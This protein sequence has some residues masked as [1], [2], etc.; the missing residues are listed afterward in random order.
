MS[1]RFRH[2]VLII[3][4]GAAGL[5]AA[6]HL[7]DH[8]RV[9]VLSKYSL[10]AG[11]TDWAQGGIAAVTDSTDTEFE[12]VQDTLRAGAGLSRE[13]TVWHTGQHVRQVASLLEQAGITP[14]RPLSARDI[15]GL[16]LTEAIW[17]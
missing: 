2:D 16:P 11:S 9:A 6:L 3:G 14:D 13:R 4:S 5:A 1:E 8:A 7:S 12:H 15:R 10:D 17:D